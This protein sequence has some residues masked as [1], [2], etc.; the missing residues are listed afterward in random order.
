MDSPSAPL[1]DLPMPAE[2]PAVAGCR[3]DGRPSGWPRIVILALLFEGGLGVLAILAGML[4]AFPPWRQLNFAPAQFGYGL[5][6]TLPML[7]ALVIIRSIRVG[8]LGR[9]NTIV[10]E[11]VAP[12][13]GK[14][15]ILQLAMISIVAGIGEELLFRGVVQ[16]LLIDWLG[17]ITGLVAASV[18][19]GLM[20][21]ITPTYALLATAVGAYLGW[22][23]LF[24]GGVIA[25][26]VAHALYDFVALIFLTRPQR[27]A[28]S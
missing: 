19:F 10:D 18:I 1:S 27:T 26:M 16:P 11:L 2:N 15:G 28:T 4:M 22:L 24:T 12:L 8:P 23:T 25:P 5:A 6:A 3:S 20:H 7:V 9:L 21:A 14:C 17:M 13:F